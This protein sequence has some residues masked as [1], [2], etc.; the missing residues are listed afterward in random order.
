MS[1][2]GGKLG[3]EWDEVIWDFKDRLLSYKYVMDFFTVFNPV[4]VWLHLLCKGKKIEV[5]WLWLQVKELG[6]FPSQ[7]LGVFKL[8][9][10]DV[11][12]LP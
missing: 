8:R 3:G 11:P 12:L 2:D 7:A 9:A 5:F 10:S 4:V 6:C 1:L